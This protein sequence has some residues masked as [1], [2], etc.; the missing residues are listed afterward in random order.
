[1]GR[2]DSSLHASLKKEG[3]STENQWI[4]GADG[5]FLNPARRNG[6]ESGG[7]V[8]ETYRKKGDTNYGK[9]DHYPNKSGVTEITGE[10]SGG[11]QSKS[12][13][14]AVELTFSGH[15]NERREKDTT[16]IEKTG[17]SI[18]D[19]KRRRVD[20]PI[21]ERPIITLSTKDDVMVESPTEDDHV[22]KNLQMAGAA[23]QT[24]QAL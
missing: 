14:T 12:R 7:G 19:L 4:R 21:I 3:I 2:Y 23:T 8:S 6:G 13:I 9:D 24:R 5:T 15:L 20:D 18:T 11:D 22:P 10:N 16:E 1:M 17:L